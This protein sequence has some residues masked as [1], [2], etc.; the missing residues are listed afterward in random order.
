MKPLYTLFLILAL[1][2]CLIKPDGIRAEGTKQVMPNTTNGTGLIVSTTSSFPLGSVGSYLGAPLDNHIQIHIADFN[3]EVFYYGFNWEPLSPSGTPSTGTYSDVYMNIYDPT[4]TLVQTVNLPSTVGTPGFIGGVNGYVNAI[5][6]PQIAGVPTN[7]YLPL[8]FTPTMNGDYYVSFYRSTDGGVTHISGGESMLAKY[9]DITVAQNSIPVAGRVHC[10]EWAFSVY[11]PAKNDIQDPATS[12]NA[13][14]YGYTPDS[15]TVKVSFPSPPLTNASGFMPLSYIIAFNSFGCIN[16]G[17]WLVDRNSIN[18]QNLVSPYLTGGFDVFLN[19]P[20]PNVYPA[21]VIPSA[22]ILLAPVISGCPP[23]PYNIRFKAPQPGDYYLLFDLNGVPGFQNNTADR[24]I[25]LIN[26]PAAIRTYVWDGKDG[27]GNVVPANTTFPIIFSYRKG[28]I[29]IPFYDVELNVNGFRVDGYAPAAAV[30]SNAILYWNDAGLTSMGNCTTGSSNNNNSSGIG[31]DNSVVGVRPVWPGGGAVTYGR[32]WN[33]NGNITNQTPADSVSYSGTYNNHDNLQCN[34]YGNA[35]LLNTW[36]W[37]ITLDTTQMLTLQCIT[38]SGTVWDDADGSANGGFTNIR[39]NGEAPTNAGNTLYA[40]LVDPITGNVLSTTTVAA[41]GTYTLVNCPVNAV[42]MEVYITTSP[43][44]VG[45]P[46]PTAQIPSTWTNT[47]PLI[48][49][50]TSGTS[51]VTG[52]DFGIEQIPNSFDQYYT[53]GTP[54]LNSF[55]PLNGSGSV[56]SPGPLTGSDPEDGSMGSGKTV[57]ITTIPSNEQ[58]YYNGS[59]LG[60]GYKITNYDPTLL[61][62]K[63]TTVNT[64]STSFQYAYVDA[65]G[66]QDPTPA[67]YTI[68]MS[69]VLAQS[70]GTFT[71]KATGQ[72]NLLTWTSLDETAA[73]RFKIQRSVDG[74]TYQNIGNVPGT[75]NGTSVNHSFTDESPIPNT[76]NNYRLEWTDG[77][78][79]LAYSNVVT[80]ASSLV[81][82][83]MDVA[84]NPFR[85][86]LTVRLSL[87][88]TQRVS[89]RLLDSKGVLVQQGQ[90]E[91]IRG[92]NTFTLEGLSSLPA[93]VYLVQIVLVDQVFV[94]KA[95][96]NR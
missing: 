77:S 42:G 10:N 80:I 19:P 57:V 37:G 73:T 44:T 9:F 55:L 17:N 26:Q 86:Q 5:R 58:L 28:R 8:S 75:G 29:N 82:A 71:G 16:N 41:D 85:D 87:I 84:P 68:N 89:I 24:F 39:T 31:Y 21:C 4:G 14:F 2:C 13:A 88:G 27:L 94:R 69:V 51:S 74:L 78:G 1:L 40:N 49:T 61:Q 96:N 79:N 22:P 72:G 95:F 36:A 3:T 25:E 56:S 23:G 50:F 92:V 45:S 81:N 7:G 60:N 65:A 64:L 38:V 47:S 76:P 34:D 43:G 12:T 70:L 83:V 54:V 32:A 20:D 30:Q 11:N 67:T 35:R 15:V 33:G 18:L 52:I 63:F 53:I 46:V 62:M 66:K 6:G 59:L 93:S 48:E 90:Y 91:G